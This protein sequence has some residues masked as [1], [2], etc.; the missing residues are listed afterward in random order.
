MEFNNHRFKKNGLWHLIVP[1]EQGQ[2][3]IRPRYPNEPLNAAFRL[4]YNV[5]C[6]EKRLVEENALSGEMR[7]KCEKWD[8]WDHSAQTLHFFATLNGEVIGRLR[9]IMDGTLGLPIERNG[10]TVHRKSGEGDALACEISK[11]MVDRRF[12]AG[13]L[14]APFYWFVY[15][16]CAVERKLPNAMLSCEPMLRA[17]YHRIGAHDLGA[18]FNKEFHKPY[19]AMQIQFADTFAWHLADKKNSM[20]AGRKNNALLGQANSPVAAATVKKIFAQENLGVSIERWKATPIAGSGGATTAGVWRVSATA[21]SVDPNEAE[22]SCVVKAIQ[23]PSDA[24]ATRANPIP[25]NHEET[26]YRRI[27]RILPRGFC[28]PRLLGADASEDKV[29]LF[30]E[31]LN[32]CH[33]TRLLLAALPEFA[34]SLGFWHG[35]ANAG[36][37]GV[38]GWLGWYVDAASSM[39]ERIPELATKVAVLAALNDDAGNSQVQSFWRQRTDALQILR[40]LPHVN[41]HQDL[42]S[43]N[44]LMRET[45]KVHEHVLLDWALYGSAPLGAELA[46]LLFGSALLFEWSVPEALAALPAVV[47]AYVDGLND[48]GWPQSREAVGLGLSLSAALRYVAW[49][50]HRAEAAL[51]ASR[52]QWAENAVGRPLSEIVERFA[53]LRLAVTTMG[54]RSL[55]G[56]K[57]NR[58]GSGPQGEGEAKPKRST[59]CI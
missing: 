46:P 30:L 50:G 16:S 45:G 55:E 31:D 53:A 51:D 37:P 2:I 44:V 14:L 42:V 7:S 35:A 38:A 48:A 21:I 54:L 27:T 24:A 23:A 26:V 20:P 5:L 40:Q 1:H 3:L 28:A 41:S 11:L 12:R 49:G 34:R 58:Q 22:W 36:K 32:S 39:V 18:F 10:F 29:H 33:T 19:S 4:A 56:E 25:W 9:I 13:G 47:N 43:R 52:H 59:A 57:R 8:D 6:A 17:L 15:Q